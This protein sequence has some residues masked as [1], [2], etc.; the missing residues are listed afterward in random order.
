MKISPIP[1]D[2]KLIADTIVRLVLITDDS[3]KAREE[4][5]EIITQLLEAYPPHTESKEFFQRLMKEYFE[6]AHGKAAQQE[7]QKKVAEIRAQAA[8]DSNTAKYYNSSLYSRVW[9]DTEP[10]KARH[11]DGS[12]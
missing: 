9:S 6:S 8:E 12:K 3:N 2:P 5:A 7:F 1:D 10:S 11:N 4:V